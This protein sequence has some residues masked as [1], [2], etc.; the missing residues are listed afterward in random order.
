M[1]RI[2]VCAENVTNDHTYFS[3]PVALILLVGCLFIIFR[4]ST[5]YYGRAA[6]ITHSYRTYS[7]AYHVYPILYSYVLLPITLW[8]RAVMKMQLRNAQPKP[9]K[10]SF[11]VKY[12]CDLYSC[13][14]KKKWRICSVN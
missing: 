7:R 3:L 2:H 12:F 1:R 5:F 4:I 11:L 14:L 13:D 9:N 6:V 10:C 8:E